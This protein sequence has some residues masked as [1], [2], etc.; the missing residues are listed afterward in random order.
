MSIVVCTWNRSGL[1]VKTLERMLDLS[2]PDG[3]GWELVVV[4]NNSTDDTQEVL[5][6]YEGVL[7]LRIVVEEK[8]GLSYARN[9]AARAAR[10]RY[11]AWTDDD[12][13]VNPAWISEYVDAFRRWPEATYFGGPVI[14]W[15]EGN[16]PGW[17]QETVHMVRGPYALVDHG[18][19]PI[20]LDRTHVAYGANFAIDRETQLDFPFDPRL[21]RVGTS[22]RSGDETAVQRALREAGHRGRWV[23]GARVRHFI[24]AE[25]QTV[26]F[27]RRRIR[28]LG[29]EQASRNPSTATRLLGR[30]RWLWKAV[31]IAE[32]RYRWH[33]L[34]SPAPTWMRW[35]KESAA[36]QGRFIGPY[37]D[38]VPDDT[39]A[40]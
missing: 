9:A 2:V 21:G 36:H 4:D 35:L 1:L 16:P 13:L 34:A 12:V 18:D 40:G 11:L 31:V 25:R 20:W 28:A 23:P 7:P 17:L 10:G 38:W 8:Q 33:R 29:R 14:P 32:L 22:L 30:P 15:F 19:E 6:R 3:V 37:P 39:T 24:P 27:L 26:A 5:S